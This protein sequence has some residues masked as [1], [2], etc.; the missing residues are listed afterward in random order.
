MGEHCVEQDQ[1]VLLAVQ[2]LL[3]LAPVARELDDVPGGLERPIQHAED[4][5]IVVHREDPGR[6]GA[7]LDGIEDLLVLAVPHLELDLGLPQLFQLLELLDGLEGRVGWR[8]PGSTAADL[9]QDDRER[10]RRLGADARPTPEPFVLVLGVIRR[11]DRLGE[12]ARQRRIG[13]DF[14]PGDEP[15]LLQHVVVVGPGADGD[16]EPAPLDGKGQDDVRLRHRSRHRVEDRKV[17]RRPGQID[18]GNPEL[19]RHHRDQVRFR[20]PEL[21]Y[22]IEERRLRGRLALC[23]FEE[24]SRQRLALR[25]Q[26]SDGLQRCHEHRLPQRN[27][28][29]DLPHAA[30]R[31]CSPSRYLR[32]SSRAQISSRAP[33]APTAQ[34]ISASP[35]GGRSAALRTGVPRAIRLR[36]PTS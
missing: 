32:A 4:V 18:A 2:L 34:S 13:R 17:D 7:N 24:R 23:A 3:G 6:T 14:L 1:V 11:G 33:A 22:R 35:G 5:E 28:G 10:R 9:R 8:G 27:L 29:C 26:A 20:N 30:K 21:Q 15:Q 36:G 16:V 31:K 25:E 12:R 19:L